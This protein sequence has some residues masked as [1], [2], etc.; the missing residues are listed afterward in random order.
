MPSSGRSPSTSGS[1]SSSRGPPWRGRPSRTVG[2]TGATT[3]QPSLPLAV[4]RR[5]NSAGR[6]PFLF[7]T[8]LGP[9]DSKAAAPIEPT[10]AMLQLG[11]IRLTDPRQPGHHVQAQPPTPPDH[12]GPRAD[13]RRFLSVHRCTTFTGKP[14]TD[15]PGAVAPGHAIPVQIAIPRLRMDSPR[16][17]W[18]APVAPGAGPMLSLGQPQFVPAMRRWS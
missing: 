12:P 1:P 14:F 9:A 8:R 13:C 3:H 18:Y 16:Q 2:G 15:A 5:C 10:L 17:A 4:I 11:Q 6:S 7:E